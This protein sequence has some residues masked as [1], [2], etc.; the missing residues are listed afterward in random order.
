M[1]AVCILVMR[2]MPRSVKLVWVMA[3]MFLIPKAPI[4]T[5]KILYTEVMSAIYTLYH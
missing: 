3:L 4:A 1:L 2:L 5:G